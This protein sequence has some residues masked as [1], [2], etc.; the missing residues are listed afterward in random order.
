MDET[1]DI[2]KMISLLEY[3]VLTAPIVSTTGILEHSKAACH[4]GRFIWGNHFQLLN[5]WPCHTAWIKTPQW[6]KRRILSLQY[7]S[8]NVRLSH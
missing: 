5:A 6:V 2:F 3:A 7:V 4:R 8:N 1:K